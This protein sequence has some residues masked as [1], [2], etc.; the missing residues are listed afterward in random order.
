MI[1]TVR[2]FALS[3]A[4]VVLLAGAGYARG[5]PA[6]SE[7]FA[8]SAV[9]IN[10]KNPNIVY[11]SSL[12]SDADK[13]SVVKSTDG[14]QTWNTADTGLT[15]PT[16]P[17]DS[18]DL[19]VDALALDPRSPN[20]LYAGTGLG[21]FKTTNGAQTW[22][23]ASKGIDVGGGLA[24]R[25]YEGF[26]YEIAVDPVHTST[27]WAAGRGVWKSTNG[28]ATW[29]HVLRRYAAISV[30]I[31]PRRPE[32]VYASLTGNARA[33]GGLSAIVKSVNG[34][35]TWRAT[36]PTDLRDNYFGHPIVVDGRSPGVVYAG[37]STGL[38]ASRNKGRTWS[39]LLSPDSSS[40]HVVAIALDPARANV[41]YVGGSGTNGSLL[42][43]DDGGQ[44]WSKLRLGDVGVIEIAPTRPQ[45]V[46]AGGFGDGLWKS[47]DGCATWHQLPLPPYR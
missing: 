5:A 17:T 7:G 44:T 19:R 38:F 8:L 2:H 32:T 30:G 41:V 45:T 3:A 34:G 29:K 47:T 4:V 10:P 43:T 42:K 21:V 36:G 20:V 33:A 15:N 35:H 11:A 1:L 31:D 14:G 23:L 13:R 46:Y 6:N 26:I 25:M 9:Q 37:G 12:V 22:K 16:S 28:G 24:H 27:V 18:T 40:G 39:K